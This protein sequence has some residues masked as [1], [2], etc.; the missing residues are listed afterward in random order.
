MTGRADANGVAFTFVNE[1]DMYNFSNIE[2]L[3]GKE[4]QKI[5]IPEHIGEGPV[6]NPKRG[7][8]PARG[9]R[10]GKRRTGKK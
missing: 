8:K 2:A 7:A 3:I 1:E 4:I 6:Y 10:K 5:R 9:A